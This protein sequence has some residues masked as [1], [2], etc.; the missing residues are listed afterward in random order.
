MSVQRVGDAADPSRP[1][2]PRP[3]V[4][5]CVRVT[6]RLSESLSVTSSASQARDDG[7]G[8][9]ADCGGAAQRGGP[10]AP[11]R[12]VAPGGKEDPIRVTVPSHSSSPHP[13]HSSS[14]HPS[15]PLC[16]CVSERESGVGVYGRWRQTTG[17][18]RRRWPSWRPSRPASAASAAAWSKRSRPG[19]LPALP[20]ARPGPVPARHP[21]PLPAPAPPSPVRR[22]VRVAGPL[23]SDASPG[24]PPSSSLSEC[25]LSESS[26][27]CTPRLRLG[28]RSA[29]VRGDYVRV[30]PL[31]LA[32]ARRARAV[33]GQSEPLPRRREAGEART[34]QKA[35][36]APA[37]TSPFSWTLQSLPIG[38]LFL[39]KRHESRH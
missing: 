38:F 23:A 2:K 28:T 32:Y 5:G 6:V 9:H 18:S 14:P 13:S 11:A 33:Q 21:V 16:V 20:P 36:P 31:S 7:G 8:A 22:P 3:L 25:R 19:L 17:P 1:P 24:L 39:T 12:R 29:P 37:T 26:P 4:V 27:R 30:L 34:R 15:H 10:P 35:K